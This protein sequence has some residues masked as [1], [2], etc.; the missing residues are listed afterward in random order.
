[1]ATYRVTPHQDDHD[2]LAEFQ[3]QDLQEAVLLGMKHAS[4]AAYKLW[5]QQADGDWVM[6]PREPRRQYGR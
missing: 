1:M 4:P 3:A 5:V 6:A 2:V